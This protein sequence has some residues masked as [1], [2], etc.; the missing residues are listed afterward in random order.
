MMNISGLE[1][2]A[3]VRQKSIKAGLVRDL[4]RRDRWV[5]YGVFV[6]SMEPLWVL[7]ISHVRST[8]ESM[9]LIGYDEEMRTPLPLTLA[10]GRPEV[11]NKNL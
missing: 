6:C 3:T 5:S 4:A 2:A 1:P 9:E 7:C 8:I 10:A 11:Q